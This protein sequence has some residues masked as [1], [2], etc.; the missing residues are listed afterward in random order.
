MEMEGRDTQFIQNSFDNQKL[1]I[2]TDFLKCSEIYSVPTINRPSI[3]IANIW[4][5]NQK[6]NAHNSYE[7][8]V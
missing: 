7:Y 8:A 3:S 4:T 1:I 5:Q 6:H 2:F